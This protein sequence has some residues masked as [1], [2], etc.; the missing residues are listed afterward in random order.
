M[1]LFNYCSNIMQRYFIIINLILTGCTVYDVNQS[2]I[3]A[4]TATGLAN[5][6]A[7]SNP[8]SQQLLNYQASTRIGT[9]IW[10]NPLDFLTVLPQYY[11]YR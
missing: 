1:E 3:T 10:E 4:S 11:L 7:G 9:T 6:F 8:V 2:R 5:T